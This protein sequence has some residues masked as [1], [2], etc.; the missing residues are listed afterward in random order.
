MRDPMRSD[1]VPQHKA[2]A[3]EEQIISE[4][5]VKQAPPLLHTHLAEILTPLGARLK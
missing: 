5:G 2:F 4:V 3:R 1:L